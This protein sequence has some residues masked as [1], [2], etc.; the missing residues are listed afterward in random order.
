MNTRW[1]WLAPALV[2]AALAQAPVAREG[3]QWVQTAAGTAEAANRI[4]VTTSGAIV[5]RGEDRR[6]VAWTV[7]KHTGVGS[8]SEAR[9]LLGRIAL[10]PSRTGNEWL[11]LAVALPAENDIGADVQLRVPKGIRQ[12]V[13]ETRGGQVEA[14]NI[15]GQVSASTGGGAVLLDRI[16]GGL[17]AGTTGGPIR[18]GQVTGQVVAFSGGGS[19]TADAINGDARLD[20]G[21]GEIVVRQVTGRMEASTRGGGNIRVEHAGKDVALATGSGMIDVLHAGGTVSAS[22]GSGGIKVRSAGN[23]ECSAGA[24]QIQLYD[25]NGGVRA[26][27]GAGSIIAE[28]VAGR[29]LRD[30]VLTTGQGDITVYIPSNFPVTIEAMNASPGGHRIVSEFSEIR[31]RVESGTLRAEAQGALNGGGPVLRLTASGGTI[32][33]RHRK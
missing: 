19:I 26:S 5:V 18:I 6:D 22:S 20:L 1:L 7:R 24:G 27:L 30:S 10:K 4:R 9:A 15:D 17:K 2:S 21:G 11:V 14:D 29:L 12:A 8:E 23:V 16:Y 3:R 13:L 31:P 32:Y 25:L 33:L 28:L